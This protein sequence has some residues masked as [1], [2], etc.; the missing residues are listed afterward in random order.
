MTSSKKIS[1]T[2]YFNDNDLFTDFNL[3]IKKSKKCNLKNKI[4]FVKND[5][6]NLE[7]E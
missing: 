4:I 7:Y 5:F 6:I 3:S 1:N 2:K